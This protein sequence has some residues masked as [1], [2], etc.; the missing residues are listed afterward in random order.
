MKNCG[1][2]FLSKLVLYIIIDRKRERKEK[3][4]EKERKGEKKREKDVQGQLLTICIQFAKRKTNSRYIGRN[5]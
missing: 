3:K 5:A 1:D 2:F 4:R